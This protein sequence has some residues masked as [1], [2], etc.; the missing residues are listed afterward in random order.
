TTFVFPATKRE[1]TISLPLTFLDLPFA[2]PKY[3]ERLFFYNFPHPTNHFYQI[4]LPSLK[5]S[6]SLTLQQFFPLV[7]NLRC[8]PPPHKPFILCTQNDAL[9][10]T[11]I[12]SSADFE[13]LSTNHHPKSVKDF[14][15]LVPKLT[16]KIDFDDNDTLIFSLM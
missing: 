14:S 11:V 2:G 13:N 15:H 5:Q 16:Q 6:H 10:L 3:V 9:T 1:T 7:G 4:T 12:E 8:P